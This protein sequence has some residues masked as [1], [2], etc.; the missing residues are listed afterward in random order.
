VDLAGRFLSP[1]NVYVCGM[2]KRRKRS[3]AVNFSLELCNE[4][5]L[6]YVGWKGK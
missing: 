6:N 4:I 1:L 5:P 2:K 3:Q